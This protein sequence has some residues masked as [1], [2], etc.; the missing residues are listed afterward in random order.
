MRIKKNKATHKNVMVQIEPK[1]VFTFNRF[2][3]P[4]GRTSGLTQT[5]HD[6]L[7][8]AKERSHVRIMRLIDKCIKQG[9]YVE[10]IEHTP[11]NKLI[12]LTEVTLYHDLQPQSVH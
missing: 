9:G 10:Y 5:Q 12:A 3:P 4:A 6:D 7:L 8:K 1:T 2:T 11:L